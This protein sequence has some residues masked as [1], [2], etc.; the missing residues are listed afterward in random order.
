MLRHIFQTAGGV[1]PSN[2]GSTT[3]R[4]VRRLDCAVINNLHRMR[5]SANEEAFD[6][7]RAAFVEG[8]PLYE[9]AGFHSETHLQVC[10]RKESQIIA[11][12]RVRQR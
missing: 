7:V 4:V 5:E 2:T 11:Y 3:D 6:S 8:A 9:G 1:L 12:F 10:V